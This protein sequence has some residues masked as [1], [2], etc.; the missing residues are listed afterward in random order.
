MSVLD[1][2]DEQQRLR[3]GDSRLRRARVSAPASSATRLTNGS[4]SPQP[5]ALREDG[6]A[7]L[8]RGGDPRG[9]RRRRRRRVDMCL[10][11]EEIGRGQL[12][13]A[14]I[15]RRRIIAAGAYERFGTEEQKQEILGGIADGAVESIAM[16][17]PEAGSDVGNLQCRAERENGGYVINGQKTWISAAQHRRPHPARLPH[18]PRGLQ[19]RGPDDAQRPRRRRRRRDP[20]HRDDGRPARSTTSSSPTASCPRSAASA[21]RATA[22]TQLMAGLERRAARSLAA[23]LRSASPSAPSTTRSPTSRS[24][25]SSTARS[26]PSRRIRHRLADLATEIECCR[27]LVY[28]VARAH[29]RQPGRDSSRARR[30]WRS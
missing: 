27:L 1:L 25:S 19:A 10:L 8:A 2:T 11:L 24:A 7:R 4:G 13:V 20:R 26:A 23:Q 18:R 6:R 22:W 14:A 5:R 12:P 29:R 16:S 15:R 9:V 21:R 3:R 28:D 17:E 30:R